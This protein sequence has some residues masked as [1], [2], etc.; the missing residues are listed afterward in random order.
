MGVIGGPAADRRPGGAVERPGRETIVPQAAYAL[1]YAADAAA[2]PA[3]LERGAR[4]GEN[5]FAA[6]SVRALVKS[7]AKAGA[8]E[9]AL[10][11]FIEALDDEY[12]QVGIAA[13]EGLQQSGDP[14][15]ISALVRASAD[16]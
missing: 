3:L 16:R 13:T 12:D 5:L 2:I 8:Y 14:R 15:A 1:Q 7:T 4:C 6:Q 11:V 10:P 9:E